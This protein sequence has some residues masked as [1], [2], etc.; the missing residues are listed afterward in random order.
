MPA[1]YQISTNSDEL[2]VQ[3]SAYNAAAVAPDVMPTAAP[4]DLR[5]TGA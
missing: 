2:S 3:E 1:E 4:A 5:W